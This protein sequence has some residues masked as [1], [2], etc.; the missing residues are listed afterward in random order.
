MIL[1]IWK[2]NFSVFLSY[3]PSKKRFFILIF[4]E[5][6]SLNM[7]KA[8]LLFIGIIISLSSFS[9]Q[10]TIG[11]NKGAVTFEEYDP[12]STLVVDKNPKIR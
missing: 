1:R 8:A 9:Q 4:T 2:N 6:S 7:K 11:D 12:K 10:I 5:N 3:S